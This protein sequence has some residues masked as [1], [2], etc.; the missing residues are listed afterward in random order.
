MLIVFLDPD[1][2]ID[3]GLLLIVRWPTGI[4]YSSQCAGGLT[5]ERSLE[6]FLIP[7]GGPMQARP[8]QDFFARHCHGNPPVVGSPWWGAI[9]T[10]EVLSEL[11]SLIAAIPI[12]ETGEAGDHDRRHFLSFDPER[13]SELTEAWAPVATPWGPGVLVWDNSD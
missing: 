4:T 1:G 10:D 5:E 12:W 11:A 8:L 2:S 3:L 9:W 6:G 13:L 7:V